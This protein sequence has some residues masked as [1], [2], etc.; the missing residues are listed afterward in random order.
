VPVARIVEVGRVKVTGGVPERYAGTV[1]PGD[2][3]QV[4]LDALSG[5]RFPASLSYVGTAVDSGSR[6]FPIEVVMDNPDGRVKPH[7]V[8]NVEIVNQRLPG[9]IVIPQDA[10][11]RT[12]DG[13]QVFV[14]VERDGIAYAE[15]RAVRL[16]PI[17][18]DR[19][20]VHEGLSDGDRL[21]VRGQKMVDAGDRLRIVGGA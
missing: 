17:S 8:A 4:T 5:R 16:G 9:A 7:M 6:T 11:I 18:D 2:T 10:V 13:Y 3:A 15:A 1:A 21:V 12:E 14:A 20:V 19:A